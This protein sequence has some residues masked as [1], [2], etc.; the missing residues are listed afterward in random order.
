MADILQQ[1]YVKVTQMPQYQKRLDSTQT[2]SPNN[3]WRYSFLCDATEI[4][5][6]IDELQA[7]D[8]R[9]AASGPD[10]FPA[11]KMSSKSAS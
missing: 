10:N 11:I 9:H 4:E 8:P 3:H 7:H 1:Q 2:C 6:A 5:E